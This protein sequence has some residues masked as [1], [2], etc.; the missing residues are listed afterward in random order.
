MPL[1]NL[2]RSL[3]RV[4]GISWRFSA[5]GGPLISSCLYCRSSPSMGANSAFSTQNP[6]KGMKRVRR[7]SGAGDQN[8]PWSREECRAVIN[9]LP[10]HLALPV[11]LAMFTGLRQGDVLALTKGAIKDGLISRRTGKTGQGVSIPVHPDLADLLANAP[12]MMQSR[13]PR[14]W[15]ESHGRRTASEP[16]WARR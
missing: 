4:C 8:R 16:R 9:E 12:S 3:W 2:T 13:S 14:T 10:P 15:P 5:A 11:A 6:V 1:A 7:P